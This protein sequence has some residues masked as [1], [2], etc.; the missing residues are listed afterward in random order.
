M[1]LLNLPLN[2]PL[3]HNLALQKFGKGADDV[4]AALLDVVDL[5]PL[6]LP[7]KAGGHLLV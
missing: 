4:V 6:D 2:F 5:L 7:Q 3:D 1:E